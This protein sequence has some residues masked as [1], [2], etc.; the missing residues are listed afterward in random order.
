M[1]NVLERTGFFRILDKR[2]E[3]VGKSREDFS[4]VIKAN[5]MFM[6]SRKDTSSYTDPELVE[7]LIDKIV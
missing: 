2:F 1:D 6:H 7:A 4:V 5:F 3:V